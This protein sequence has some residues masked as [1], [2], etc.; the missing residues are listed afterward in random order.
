MV[1]LY[2]TQS[3]INVWNML[4]YLHVDLRHPAAARH[5]CRYLRYMERQSGQTTK[6]PVTYLEKVTLKLRYPLFQLAAVCRHCCITF[7]WLKQ[8][9][10]LCLRCAQFRASQSVA[11]KQ[12]L[13]LSKGIA[14]E[15][16][17][18]ALRHMCSNYYAD[19]LFTMAHRLSCLAGCLSARAEMPVYFGQSSDELT[20]RN[21]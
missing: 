4:G 10:R 20:V 8:G 3:V 1:Q 17:P 11:A 15:Q 6:P 16:K 12:I 7:S 19:N 18:A 13:H 5:T 2:L 14:L 21:F 9:T